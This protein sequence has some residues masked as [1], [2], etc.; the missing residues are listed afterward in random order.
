MG[1]KGI[2][3]V[4]PETVP[5]GRR[6]GHR[7][8]VKGMLLVRPG[9]GDPARVGVLRPGRASTPRACGRPPPARPCTRTTPWPPSARPSRDG[10]AL[11]VARAAA[12]DPELFGRFLGPA[13]LGV[14]S[15]AAHRRRP[16][17]MRCCPGCRSRPP[18][19]TMTLTSVAARFG[20]VR[21]DHQVDEFRQLAPI[22]AAQG[23]R[24]S[25]TPATP[26]TANWSTGCPR[27]GPRPR[28][29]DLDPEPS[30]PTSTPSTGRPELAA[31]AY[32]A[33]ARDALAVFDCDVAL[34]DLPARLRARPPR[35]QPRGPAR[36]HPLPARP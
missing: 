25:S 3:C 18:T 12:S 6:H 16:G 20:V 9:R 14:K 32:L 26:T 1:L 17:R 21:Y 28:V 27:S 13:P 15:L 30:P 19:G 5:A 33:Q 7:V 31:A 2:A 11:D 29:A 36:A 24:A 22:A 23:T 35:R 34:R 4:L 10:C 8:H